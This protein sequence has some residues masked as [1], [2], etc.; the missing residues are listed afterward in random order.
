MVTGLMHWG[1]SVFF[2]SAFVGI[3]LLD[4]FFAT[5][6]LFHRQEWRKWF[7]YYTP[8]ALLKPMKDEIA[9]HYWNHYHEKRSELYFVIVVFV[10]VFVF[11]GFFG[12]GNIPIIFAASVILVCLIGYG[13]IRG[14]K[15][16]LIRYDHAH[17]HSIW[18]PSGGRRAYLGTRRYE[19][20]LRKR[21]R[22]KKHAARK[23]HDLEIFK[24]HHPKQ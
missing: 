5:D 7:Q 14:N 12:A 11:W 15:K 1:W 4:Y 16:R 8:R 6:I 21:E 10:F 20:F 18:N 9:L 23:K 13:L 22:K 2:V 19:I 17:Y 24:K 3:L